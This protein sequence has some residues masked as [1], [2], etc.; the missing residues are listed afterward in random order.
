M[1]KY[2][3]WMCVAPAFRADLTEPFVYIKLP[4]EGHGIV[5]PRNSRILYVEDLKW[6]QK[7]I[8]GI[9]WEP[10]AAKWKVKKHKKRSILF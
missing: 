2:P 9:D 1:Q 7:Y 6:M 8:R 10:L 5:E 4:R 3:L